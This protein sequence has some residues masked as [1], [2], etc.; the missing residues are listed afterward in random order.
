VALVQLDMALGWRS[1]SG[2]DSD[3]CWCSC[4]GVSG[5]CTLTSAGHHSLAIADSLTLYLAV[6]VPRVPG[7]RSVGWYPGPCRLILEREARVFYSRSATERD[8]VYRRHTYPISEISAIF[9]KGKRESRR[10]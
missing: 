9:W 3:V 6:N 2:V 4:S 7:W 8:T 5:A 1:G 10:G